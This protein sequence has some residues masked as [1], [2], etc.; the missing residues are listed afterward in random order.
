[1]LLDEGDHTPGEFLA[2]I[3]KSSDDERNYI[4][5]AVNWALRQI[6]KRNLILYKAA[7]LAAKETKN[8]DSK[9]P[10]RLASDAIRELE[11]EGVKKRLGSR[12]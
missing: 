9:A 8:S 2:I 1:M 4:K 10:R 7:L 12:N 3:E 5:K 11:S 6:G